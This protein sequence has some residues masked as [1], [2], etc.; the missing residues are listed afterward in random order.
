MLPM[1]FTTLGLLYGDQHC[2]TDKVLS[3]LGEKPPGTPVEIALI[4]LIE[5]ERTAHCERHHSLDGILY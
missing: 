5:T 2:Q 1:A 4:T 3:H